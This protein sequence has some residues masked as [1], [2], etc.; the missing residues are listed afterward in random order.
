MDLIVFGFAAE[1]LANTKTLKAQSVTLKNGMKNFIQV[2]SKFP[3]KN[4]L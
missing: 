1:K 3:V 2:I 4:L